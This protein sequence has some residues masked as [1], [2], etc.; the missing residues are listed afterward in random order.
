MDGS[1]GT[2]PQRE[3]PVLSLERV[4]V[5]GSERFQKSQFCSL[6][7]QDFS[8][9]FCFRP[10]CGIACYDI[11]SN[12]KQHGWVGKRKHLKP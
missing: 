8:Y 7:A 11:E 10:L 4:P 1:Q 3:T 9:Q 12:L 5:L 2:L 6:T